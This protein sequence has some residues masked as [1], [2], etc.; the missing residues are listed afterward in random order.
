MTWL[1]ALREWN[2]KKGGKYVIPKKGT[3]EYLQVKK[4]QEKM[5]DDAIKEESS[6]DSGS[7][8]SE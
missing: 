4:I 3:P 1:N 7:D 2:K 8:S 5:K 6:S